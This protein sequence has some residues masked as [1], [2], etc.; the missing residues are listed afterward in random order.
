MTDRIQYGT[1]LFSLTPDWRA[2]ESATSIL[3]RVGDAGCGPALEVIGHQAWRGFPRSPR[4]TSAPSA[5][6]STA[7]AWSR[8]HWA[9]T[10]TCSAGPAAR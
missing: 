10:P 2:G 5:T 7:S 8:S 9:S 4:P 1:T 3:Q 6:P